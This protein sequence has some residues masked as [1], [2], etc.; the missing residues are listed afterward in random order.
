MTHDMD[1]PLNDCLTYEQDHSQ[2]QEQFDASIN[3]ILTCVERLLQAVRPCQRA[4]QQLDA[5]PEPPG[6]AAAA[7]VLESAGKVLHLVGHDDTR[8]G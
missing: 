4:R 8:G 1:K 6:R 3:N 7:G 2:C 5:Q